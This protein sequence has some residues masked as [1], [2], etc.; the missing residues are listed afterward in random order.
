M[1]NYFPLEGEWDGGTI[2]LHV[3]TF[4]SPG[5]FNKKLAQK[6]ILTQQIKHLNVIRDD[7]GRCSDCYLYAFYVNCLI[8]SVIKISLI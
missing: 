8:D 2:K 4:V 1:V 6:A 7:I 3:I 5:L